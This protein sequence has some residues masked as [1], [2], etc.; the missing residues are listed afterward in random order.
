MWQVVSGIGVLQVIAV[1]SAGT[2]P[3]GW[4]LETLIADGQP[5][6]TKAL[7]RLLIAELRVHRK[8]DIQPTYRVLT[9]DRFLT[10]GLR[11]VRKWAVRESNPEPW[12]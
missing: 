8:A 12:A 7:L 10:A 2:V 6:Q 5:A 11:N 3:H 1:A 9:P 4:A